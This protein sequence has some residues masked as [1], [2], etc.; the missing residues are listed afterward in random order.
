MLTTAKLVDLETSP[1][2]PKWGQDF[3][4]DI[5]LDLDETVN[6]GVVIANMTWNRIALLP[7]TSFPLC[8]SGI[9][10]IKCPMEQGR[11]H[12]VETVKV[13]SY[14]PKGQ[15]DAYVVARDE[16]S[17]QLGCVH[18]KLELTD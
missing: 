8:T 1:E 11:I 4:V 10:G 15:Y 7:T 18:I 16:K 14:F 6:D 12:R 13:P 17:E 2:K 5:T 3:T 9:P